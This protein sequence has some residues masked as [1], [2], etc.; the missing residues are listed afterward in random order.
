M[1]QAVSK[2]YAKALFH[3]AEKENAVDAIFNDLQTIQESIYN[4]KKFRHLLFNPNLA[5]EKRD[6]LFEQAL[7]GKA[8]PLTM[9]FLKLINRKR[10]ENLFPEI[11]REFTRIRNEAQNL[12]YAHITTAEPMDPRQREQLLEML[13]SDT[14]KRIQPEFHIDPN[15]LAGVKVIYSNT[16]LDGTLEGAIDRL[17]DHLKYEVLKQI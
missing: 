12:L 9:Q 15:A 16:Q 1:E 6:Q 14:G 13:E 4:Q 17:G 11:V 2:K 7:A 5:R 3:A 8:H 10:R